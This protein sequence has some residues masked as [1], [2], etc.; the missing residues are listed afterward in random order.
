[1]E[2]LVSPGHG[3]GDLKMP[4]KIAAS[5]HSV[6]DWDFAWGSNYITLSYDK[7]ISPPTSLKF[8]APHMSTTDATLCRIP[9]TLVLPEGEV[10]TWHYSWSSLFRPALFRNQT[11]LGSADYRDTYSIVVLDGQARFHYFSSYVDHTIQTQPCL[12][13]FNQWNHWRVAWYNGKTPG[14]VPA[15]CLDLYLEVAGEW[16]KQGETFYHTAN[17]WKDSGINRC[18]FMHTISAGKTAYVDDTEIWGPV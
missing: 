16:Q 12:T 3:K 11:A 1:M 15:L 4:S 5:H 18:G 10:R 7:F 2:Q 6:A 13:P 9:S 17:R 14:D 8:Y